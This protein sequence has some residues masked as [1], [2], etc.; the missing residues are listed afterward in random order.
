MVAL[1]L[2]LVRPYHTEQIGATEKVATG[3]VATSYKQKK[4]ATIIVIPISI[5]PPKQHLPEIIGAAAQR[6]MWEKMI[7]RIGLRLVEI[8]MWVRPEQ[9]AER[10]LR[11]RLLKS[12]DLYNRPDP[13]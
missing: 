12:I 3:F 6:I 7:I 11:R 4:K 13:R 8:R 5:Q 1:A 2:R 10:P 9:V